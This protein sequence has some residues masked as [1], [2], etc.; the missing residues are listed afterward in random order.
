MSLRQAINAKCKECIYD[1]RD[2]GTCAQQIAC[3]T[4]KS[5]PLYPVRPI[6]TNEIPS[7]LIRGWNID[8]LELDEKVRGLVVPRLNYPVEP[9]NGALLGSE[10]ILIGGDNEK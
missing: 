10:T 6:T 1:P 5:C 7:E 3:C 9:Q 2:R 8:P 4:V